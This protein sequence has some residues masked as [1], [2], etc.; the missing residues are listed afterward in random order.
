VLSDLKDKAHHRNLQMARANQGLN[1]SNFHLREVSRGTVLYGFC[2]E[3]VEPVLGHAALEGSLEEVRTSLGIPDGTDLSLLADLLVKKKHAME[4]TRDLKA[5]LFQ[6]G[7]A[8]HIIQLKGLDYMKSYRGVAALH[9]TSVRRIETTDRGLAR[10]V[11]AANKEKKIQEGKQ[12][13]TNT[14]G[15]GGGK[16]PNKPSGGKKPYEKPWDK[17]PQG[18]AGNACDRPSTYNGNAPCYHCKGPSHVG[19]PC[20]PT[21]K[22]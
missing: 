17:K 5:Q 8:C 22:A 18:G 2:V 16:A 3:E 9:E 15:G 6:D 20:P 13:G 11:A 1:K 10:T 14:G 19:Y 21:P 7:Q 12:G 4:V